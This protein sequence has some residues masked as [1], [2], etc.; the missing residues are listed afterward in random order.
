MTPEQEAE[1]TKD[2]FDYSEPSLRTLWPIAVV[3]VLSLMSF[4]ALLI[5]SLMSFVAL[6]LWG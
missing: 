2:E 3:A 1:Y 4:V 6:L 5:L